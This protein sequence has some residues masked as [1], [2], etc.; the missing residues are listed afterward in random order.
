[1]VGIKVGLGVAVAVWG[2]VVGGSGTLVT[3]GTGVNV[4][5]TTGV[6]V[7]IRVETRFLTVGATVTGSTGVRGTV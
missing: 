3:S 1:M 5:A 6:A 7:G 2:V 4:G